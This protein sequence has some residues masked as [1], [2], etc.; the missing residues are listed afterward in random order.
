M[1]YKQ[2]SPLLHESAPV[3]KTT[4]NVLDFVGDNHAH[5]KIGAAYDKASEIYDDYILSESFLLALLKKL[6]LGIGKEAETECQKI[7]ETML[8]QV[9]E[10]T[11]LDVPAGTGAFTFTEYAKYPK[12]TFIAVEYSLGMLKK[13]A[14]RVKKL[15]AKNIILVRADV[16][17]LP[18]KDNTFDAVLCLNGIHSFPEKT[19]AIAEMSR[20]LK[21]DKK[22]HGSLILGKERWLTDMILEL[23]YYRLLWFTKPAITRQEFLGA[24]EKNGLSVD[25]FKLLKCAGVFEAV[26]S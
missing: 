7:V 16:G 19:K 26:K 21:K 2:I 8:D 12:I 15:K 10:G 11:I 9:G 18:F 6:A 4:G 14:E 17:Q 5:K 24:L 3:L 1:N 20:I 23:A 22:F 13:A 25:N